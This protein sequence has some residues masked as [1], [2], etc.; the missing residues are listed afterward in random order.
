M[1]PIAQVGG[2]AS[3][4]AGG[5]VDGKRRE[6]AEPDTAA[7]ADALTISPEAHQ[8]AE[9]ARLRSAGSIDGDSAIREQLVESARQNIREGAYRIQEIVE[10]DQ[11]DQKRWLKLQP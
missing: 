2:V 3:P 11:N 4:G 10:Q 1:L 9:M 5:A 6:A 8:A 7:H